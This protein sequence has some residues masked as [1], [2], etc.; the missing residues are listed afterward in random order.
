MNYVPKTGWTID[1]DARLAGL[2]AR[3]CSHRKCQVSSLTAVSKLMQLVFSNQGLRKV[4]LSRGKE[5]RP[6][7]ECRG[8]SYE[9]PE[10]CMSQICRIRSCWTGL[11]LGSGGVL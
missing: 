4:E 5:C 10:R 8:P 11:G 3:G 1:D 9:E 2:L 7:K 6:G